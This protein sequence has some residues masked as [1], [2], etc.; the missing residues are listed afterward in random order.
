MRETIP[1]KDRK[2]DYLYLAFFFLN[3]LYIT[4]IVDLEQIV[5]KDPDHF[6]YPL[7]P[8]PFLVDMVHWWGS[9]FDP[10]QWARPTWWKATIWLDALFFGPYYLFAIYAF[11]KGKEWIR[12][13]TIIF[14]SILFT[15]VTIIM[16]E[17][18]WGPHATPQLLI[19][20]L[21]NAP[22]FF[23][24]IFLIWKMW[25]QEHPFTRNA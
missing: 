24:P 2:I 1:L 17:E 4:Y 22:W 19:V 9:H 18:I 11:I 14:G 16:S 10:L 5:I 6:S 25:K 15:N 7:W 13:P 12:I 23:V 21:A 3:I 8:L 20:T